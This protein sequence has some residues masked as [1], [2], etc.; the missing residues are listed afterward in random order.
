MNK[1]LRNLLNLRFSLFF[2]KYYHN[3]AVQPFSKII[4][5]ILI[6]FYWPKNR[7]KKMVFGIGLS[8]TGTASLN[9]AL[10]ELGIKSK[11]FIFYPSTTKI[12]YIYLALKDA[13]AAT[14]I[15][16]SANYK[17]IDKLYPNS[18][19]ILTIRE[20]E[21][22]LNSCKFFFTY[23]I[24]IEKA[25]KWLKEIHLKLYNTLKYDHEKFRIGYYNHLKDVQNYF[26]NRP[27]DLIIIDI[28]GGEGYEKLCP[29]LGLGVL[30]K[31]FP[32]KN[33]GN[34]T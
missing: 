16:I 31:Q 15:P 13:L 5:K 1:L 8:R 27:E 17:R 26:R 19:F 18:K 29:F 2:I 22:W 9:A 6:L 30:K 14:D 20:I 12:P 25:H 34:I 10:N 28:V 32:H 21:S 24:N 7:N 23:R 3:L 4:A 33:I 11:H